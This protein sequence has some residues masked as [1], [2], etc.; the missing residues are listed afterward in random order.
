MV[1]E[2]RNAKDGK[3]EKEP[4]G[5]IGMTGGDSG[6]VRRRRV[7]AAKCMDRAAECTV[8][9]GQGSL[10]VR[11]RKSAGCIGDAPAH[12]LWKVSRV[13]ME[14]PGSCGASALSCLLVVASVDHVRV[15]PEKGGAGG[16]AMMPNGGSWPRASNREL[17]GFEFFA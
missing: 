15:G 11:E 3:D 2:E 13:L 1:R 12:R 16:A 5:P 4:T 6:C 14:A 8:D 10:R 9:R 17:S 7:G